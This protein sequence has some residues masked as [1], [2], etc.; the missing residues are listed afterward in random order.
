MENPTQ[1]PR[2]RGLSF[3]SNKSRDPPAPKSPKSPSSKHERKFSEHLDP[4]S[5][6]DPNHAMNELQPVA[7]ALEKPTLQ[8]LRSFQ[9]TDSSG[10]PI[11]DPDLSN[12]TRSRW[13][14]PLD[15]IR[16]FEAAIDGEY[17][18]RSQSMRVDNTDHGSRRSSYYGGGYNDQNR[19][20]NASYFPQR[21]YG[22]DSYADGHGY[23]GPVGGGPPPPRMRYGNRMQSDPGWTN[24]QSMQGVY[25][26]NGYQK[27]RDTVHTNGSNGSHS[28]GPYSN[29]PSSDNSSIERGV[30]VQPPQQDLSSQYAFINNFGRGPILEEFGER[31]GYSSQGAPPPPQHNGMYSNGSPPQ[32]PKHA[33]QPAPAPIKLDSGSAPAPE[34]SR[35]KMLSKN[36]SNAGEKRKSWLK[37]RFSKG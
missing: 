13:E 15:T 31:P 25:P 33:M 5:K 18:R 10:N 19:Q 23:G 6:A 36:S 11:V 9:H 17:R 37:K 22:R 7:A 20:S 24:R 27:S 30:P 34:Q 8:S 35:P 16:S 2:Q 14:R 3:H 4:N 12:P 29:D 21:Q 28:D 26:M 1:K 32:P